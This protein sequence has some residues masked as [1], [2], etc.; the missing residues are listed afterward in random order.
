[1][2]TLEPHLPGI[3]TRRH[4]PSPAAALTAENQSTYLVSYV[5]VLFTSTGCRSRCDC[6]LMSLIM[7]FA[8]PYSPR[9]QLRVHSANGS[10]CGPC[11]QGKELFRD[12]L[13]LEPVITLN[14]AFCEYHHLKHCPP[15]EQLTREC[16]KVSWRCAKATNLRSMILCIKR[17]PNAPKCRA[18]ACTGV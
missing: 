9:T 18:L 15:S 8:L 14:D 2:P 16:K 3:L 13:T 12:L 11:V 4:D 1:M 17:H 7:N 5:I 6:E 10:P